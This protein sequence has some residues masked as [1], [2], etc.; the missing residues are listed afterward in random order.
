MGGDT[1]NKGKIAAGRVAEF[2]KTSKRR[3]RR[4]FRA[5]PG[6]QKQRRGTCWMR[7][8]GRCF[9][10]NQKNKKRLTKKGK[11]EKHNKSLRKKEKR[12]KS[13]HIMPFTCLVYPTGTGTLALNTRV[14]CFRRYLVRVPTRT[15][16]WAPNDVTCMIPNKRKSDPRAREQIAKGAG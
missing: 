6:K 14:Q 10:S 5:H 16:L 1:H 12:K 3:M 8:E 9:F 7:C 4:S 15:V 11:K 13:Y 2:L